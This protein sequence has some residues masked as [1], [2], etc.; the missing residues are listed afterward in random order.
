MMNPNVC[1]VS[2]AS[3]GSKNCQ[4][5][6]EKTSKEL[7]TILAENPPRQGE[8]ADEGMLSD[9]RSRVTDKAKALAD[10]VVACRSLKVPEREKLLKQAVNAVLTALEHESYVYTRKQTAEDIIGIAEKM[11]KAR[12]P[13]KSIG[14][15]LDRAQD[16]VFGLKAQKERE[17]QQGDENSWWNTIDLDALSG[18]IAKI[19][20]QVGYVK[21][22]KD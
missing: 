16:I 7:G 14:W 15:A 21:L 10:A 2:A 6:L 13:V 1:L 17:E 3:S 5:G 22:L 11:A 4:S 20:Q 19:R 12:V 8:N 9:W 18:D